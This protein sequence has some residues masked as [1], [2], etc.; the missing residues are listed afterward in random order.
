M[1]VRPPCLS[2]RPEDDSG[3][4]T[5]VPSSNPGY[6][7]IGGNRVEMVL[8]FRRSVPSMAMNTPQ[9]I[10]AAVL[11]LLSSAQLPAGPAAEV[12]PAYSRG[13]STQRDPFVDGRD[14]IA[15]ARRTGRR[16]LIEV[17]GDWCSWCHVLE[18]V[19]RENP[20]VEQALRRHFVVMKV[21]VS[22]ANA[23]AEFIQGLPAMAG[24][25][26]LF[27]SGGDGTIIHAQDPAEFLSGG[28]YDPDLVL[29]FLHRWADAA[30]DE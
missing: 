28:S 14:A 21:N 26:K 18:R 15:L 30:G 29:S 25:P 6:G 20:R 4:G 19:M 12:L 24:Y 23:N 10:V 5:D 27:V 22:D 9:S 2:I 16:V 7:G 3:A 11:L 13:Y 8:P 17:G 1:R